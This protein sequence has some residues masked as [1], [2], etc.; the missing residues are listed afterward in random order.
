MSDLGLVELTRRRQG[1]SLRELF[2]EHCAACS[3][4]GVVPT[5]ELGPAGSRRTITFKHKEDEQS[6]SRGGQRR[7]SAFTGTP[8]RAAT[9][10]NGRILPT[11]EEPEDALSVVPQEIL[12]QVPDDTLP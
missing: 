11:V 4:I 1:Q 6:K 12:E 8:L 10:S 7:I 5:L 2:T 9:A 3:G